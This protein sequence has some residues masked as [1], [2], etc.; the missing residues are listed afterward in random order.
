MAEWKNMD[1]EVKKDI[2]KLII[3]SKIKECVSDLQV[4]GDVSSEL[5][6]VVFE[7][8]QKA[9]DR[10]KKNGRRTLYGRDL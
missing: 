8:L 6:K 10:A 9:S 3:E 5:N 7:I 2:P 1:S 4:A